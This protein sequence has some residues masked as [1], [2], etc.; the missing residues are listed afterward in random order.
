MIGQILTHYQIEAKLGS[1]GMGEVYLA[2]DQVLGRKVALKV[3]RPEALASPSGKERFLREARAIAALN[4][5]G[6]A[7]LYETGES[8]GRPFLVM[9]YVEGR[10]L[11]EE[12]ASGP[13]LRPG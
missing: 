7:I 12:L 8:D 13:Y 2:R 3:L 4:H 5:P 10:S 11:K 9:E 6:I 1:G